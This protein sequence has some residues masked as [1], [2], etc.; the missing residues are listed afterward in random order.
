M[1]QTVSFIRVSTVGVGF[2]V[3]V[4]E[5]GVPEQPSAVGVTVMVAV[6]GT[7]VIFLAV[8]ALISPVPL[9]ANPIDVS[10]LVQV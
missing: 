6:T 10:L 9:A 8:K 5:T 1:L 2:T 3:M 7:F 4:N